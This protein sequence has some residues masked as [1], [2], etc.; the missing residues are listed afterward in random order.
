MADELPV[1]A[2]WCAALGVGLLF[3]AAVALVAYGLTR[4]RP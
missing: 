3:A 1:W 2:L 4:N